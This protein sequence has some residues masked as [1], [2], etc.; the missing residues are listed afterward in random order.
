M[1]HLDIQSVVE[2][3]QKAIRAHI[4]QVS[5]LIDDDAQGFRLTPEVLEHFAEPF[6][7]YLEEIK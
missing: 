7:I 5:D 1:L 6:A 2:I 4:S 3:K